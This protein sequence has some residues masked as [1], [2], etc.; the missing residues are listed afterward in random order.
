MASEVEDEE[1]SGGEDEIDG[2]DYEDEGDY[3]DD[4]DPMED[5]EDEEDDDPSFGERK[6]K[7]KLIKVKIPK[8]AKS[9]PSK[10]KKRK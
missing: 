8:E 7:K 2:A 9:G 3:D 4:D 1:F 10:P 5:E 6:K